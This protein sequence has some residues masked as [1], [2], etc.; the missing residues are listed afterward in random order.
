[1]TSA[2][3]FIN[4]NKSNKTTQLLSSALIDDLYDS[5][6]FSSFVN[7]TAPPGTS[8]TEKSRHS[9]ILG[10]G[11]L[12]NQA[13]NSFHKKRELGIGGKH[14]KSDWDSIQT[15]H[16]S[17]LSNIKALYSSQNDLSH[18][19][20]VSLSQ[21]SSVSKTIQTELKLSK[22]RQSETF[23]IWRSLAKIVQ[24]ESNLAE[25]LLTNLKEKKNAK[26]REWEHYSQTIDNRDQSRVEKIGARRDDIHNQRR[27]TCLQ[28]EIALDIEIWTKNDLE[29]KEKME[30]MVIEETEKAKVIED[31]Q[32]Q[33]QN[34]INMLKEKLQLLEEE[35][36]GYQNQLFNLEK[37]IQ[38]KL[39]PLATKRTSHMQESAAIRRRQKEIDERSDALDAEDM[40]LSREMK[41]HEE[42]K[43][44]GLKE[45]DELEKEI[46]IIS[47]KRIHGSEES[48]EI[49]RIQEKILSYNKSL[50]L[51]IEK[52]K[53]NKTD[54]MSIINE[55]DSLENKEYEN[56]QRQMQLDCII[57]QFSSKLK[58]LERQKHLAT[59]MDQLEKVPF[60]VEQIQLTE[61]QLDTTKKEKELSSQPT[62]YQANLDKKK[63]ELRSKKEEYKQ[64]ELEI[65][66]N[67]LSIVESSYTEL[68]AILNR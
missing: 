5:K 36:T 65:E 60:I 1:M 21:L 6:E 40:K 63:E 68:S 17:L 46:M 30:E 24:E 67:I 9:D 8:T 2:F 10:R 50:Q 57:L 22:N 59:D 23:S 45:I 13:P 16:K 54:L 48:Q 27:Y 15:K 42:E 64:L 7:Q 31:K 55:V 33:I 14:K 39:E 52:T 29:L 61:K 35:K 62:D 32:T 56:E 49:M 38:N 25:G 20:S 4:S 53:R 37:S 28:S 66:R 44:R 26:E 58:N 19:A 12:S 3:S 47:D 11:Q 43:G 41:L 51:E 34:E 18:S